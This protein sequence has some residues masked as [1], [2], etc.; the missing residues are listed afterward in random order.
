M[1]DLLSV[2]TVT[3]A[4][5]ITSFLLLFL[6]M[7]FGILQGYPN[8]QPKTKATLYTLHES[9]SW[10]GLLI[11]G[12]HVFVL[13]FDKYVGYSIGEL[14]I[15]FTES[16]KP[17][18]MGIG[19]IAFYLMAILIITSDFRHKMSKKVWKTIHYTSVLC[20]AGALWHGIFAGTDTKYFVVQLMYWATGFA[21]IL[22][23]LLRPSKQVKG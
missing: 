20:F 15:P 18:L 19:T 1:S 13:L 22:L 23:V 7:V 6:S 5:G 3:R 21:I 8:L 10:F 4:A 11:A 2:W 12:L 17:V 9:T 16:S 14:L